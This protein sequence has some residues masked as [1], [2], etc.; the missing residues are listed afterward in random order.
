MVDLGDDNGVDLT[1]GDYDQRRRRGLKGLRRLDLGLDP[2][3]TASLFSNSVCIGEKSIN[4]EDCFVLKLEVESSTLEARS[5]NSVEII[6]HTVW[7]Y[8]SQ[9]TGIIIQLEDSQLLRIKT[10][11]S[12]NIFWETTMESYI[13][14]YRTIDGINIAHAGK[15][16]V[17]LFR[18]G[19]DSEK[20]SRTLMEEFWSI[21]EVEFNI[22]GLSI[23]CFLPPADLK[24]EEESYTVILPSATKQP[25]PL[26]VWPSTSPSYSLGK[27]LSIEDEMDN[28]QGGE[29]L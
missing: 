3:L 9:R 5:T 29:D 25:P 22:K 21:V 8:F 17:S 16:S 1:V 10:S 11:K 20:N 12:E 13:Q 23:D 15:T 14:D 18:Y 2:R 27:V 6:R 28:T 4:D 24:N 26:K 7:G 19:E